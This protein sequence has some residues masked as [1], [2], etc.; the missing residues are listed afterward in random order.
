MYA[1]FTGHHD[2]VGLQKCTLHKD[3]VSKPAHKPERQLFTTVVGILIISAILVTAGY[4]VH[5]CLSG[6]W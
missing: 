4:R 3:F 2:S 5:Y 6:V 1:S